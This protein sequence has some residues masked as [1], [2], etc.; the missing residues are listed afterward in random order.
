ML[1]LTKYEW[2]VGARG[3]VL[4]PVGGDSPRMYVSVKHGGDV[5]EELRAL[6]GLTGQ[7]LVAAELEKGRKAR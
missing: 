5:L 3:E 4:A 2:L 6:E 7:A 1:I